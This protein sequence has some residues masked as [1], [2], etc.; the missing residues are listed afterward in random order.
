MPAAPLVTYAIVA[1]N[2]WMYAHPSGTAFALIPYDVTHDVVLPPPSPPIPALTLVTSMFVHGGIAHLGF[3]MLFLIVVGPAVEAI[4]GHARFA[5]F[6]LFCGIAGGAL[7]LAIAPNS[8][9]PTIG[10]SGAIAGVLGG[11]LVYPF[12]PVNTIVPL[13][14]SPRMLRLVAV[15]LIGLWAA[16]QFQNG[17]G[18]LGDGAA[19]SQGGPAYFVHIAGFCAGV[20]V[21]GLFKIRSAA[22]RACWFHS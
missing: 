13:D 21:I 9:V 14:L 15:L 20:L 8:H 7:Q 2:L 11:Y 17:F 5:L 22:R 1:L 6:Y 19:E 12:L 18:T 10:A 3:N 16:V 4:C